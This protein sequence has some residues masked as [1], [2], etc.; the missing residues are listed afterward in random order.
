M[1]GSCF[2]SGCSEVK[3]HRI[4]RIDLARPDI[5]WNCGKRF[6]PNNV[7]FYSELKPESVFLLA[8]GGDEG[9]LRRRRR[10]CRDSSATSD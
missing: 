10:T 8:C 6:R 3:K 5:F 2:L 7:F 4:K 1:G 9:E